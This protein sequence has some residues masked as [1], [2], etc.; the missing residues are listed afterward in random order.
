LAASVERINAVLASAPDEQRVFHEL[1][2]HARY[3]PA[4]RHRYVATLRVTAEELYTVDYDFPRLTSDSFQGGIPGGVDD[5]TYILDLG[6]CQPWR[7]AT[8]P[9]EAAVVRSAFGAP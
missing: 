6:A 4:D 7:T 3:N 1:L 9:A 2:G 8:K 5:I